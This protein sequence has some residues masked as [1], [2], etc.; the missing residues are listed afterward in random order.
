MGQDLL[1]TISG[2]HIEI[3]VAGLT[4]RFRLERTGRKND[5]HFS[6]MAYAQT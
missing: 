2:V 1:L 3:S 4:A 6:P 5:P